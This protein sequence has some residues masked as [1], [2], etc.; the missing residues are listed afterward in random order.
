[1]KSVLSQDEVFFGTFIVLTVRKLIRYFSY[2]TRKPC[3]CC[4]PRMTFRSSFKDLYVK[5]A[6]SSVIFKPQ[7]KPHFWFFERKVWINSAL[8]LYPLLLTHRYTYDPVALVALRCCVPAEW[9][10]YRKRHYLGES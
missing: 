1:M 3:P 9:L 2:Y 5:S 7:S 10:L 8:D 4:L 6:L